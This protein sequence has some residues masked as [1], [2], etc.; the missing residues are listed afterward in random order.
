MANDFDTLITIQNDKEL[1]QE[2]RKLLEQKANREVFMRVIGGQKSR[3]FIQDKQ[4][5]INAKTLQ[6]LPD[7]SFAKRKQYT[8]TGAHSRKF[9]KLK[10]LIVKTYKS[11]TD[12]INASI[13]LSPNVKGYQRGI[14]FSIIRG[15][16][17]NKDGAKI[18][19]KF[20]KRG[21]RANALTKA[22]KYIIKN[23]NAYVAKY[24]R[25]VFVPEFHKLNKED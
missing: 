22:K 21:T 16:R 12:G 23:D 18:K 10:D 15:Y 13:S 25:E 6:M 2:F 1:T 7:S 11:T 3:E 9:G 5:K 14:Y 20:S 24:A 17:K 19:Y 8:N 4:N